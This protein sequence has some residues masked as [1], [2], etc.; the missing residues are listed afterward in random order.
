MLIEGLGNVSFINGL[1]RIQTLRVNSEGKVAES[2]TIEIPGN[3][4]GDVINSFATAAQGI[5][6]KIGD[7]T[8][9]KSKD[10]EHTS[11]GKKH[12]KDSKKKK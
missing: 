11:N 3:K 7:N 5:S 12:K 8:D 4:V 6:D 2:G 10:N 1:L 9:V